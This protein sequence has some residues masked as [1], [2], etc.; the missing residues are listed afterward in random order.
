M[1]TGRNFNG[2]ELWT[3]SMNSINADASEKLSLHKVTKRCQHCGESSKNVVGNIF[4]LFG[5]Y[6]SGFIYD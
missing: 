1:N 4:N 3:T 2:N 5:N 6:L